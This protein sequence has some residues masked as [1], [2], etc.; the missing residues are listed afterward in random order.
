MSG[1]VPVSR[2]VVRRRYRSKQAASRLTTSRLPLYVLLGSDDLRPFPN[3]RE[4]C[5]S[6]MPPPNSFPL[7]LSCPGAC[8]GSPPAGGQATCLEAQPRMNGAV[9][10]EHVSSCSVSSGWTP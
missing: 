7:T 1:L 9:N 6:G 3:R 4:A 2:E 8:I 10:Q 5:H